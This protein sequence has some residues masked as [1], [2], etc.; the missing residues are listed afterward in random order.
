[1][2]S[3][4]I[5]LSSNV[6][7][8]LLELLVV[9]SIIAVLAGILLPVSQGVLENARKV[10]AKTT[11]QG[12][13]TAVKAYQTEYGQYPVEPPSPGAT[14]TDV[15]FDVGAP[16]LDSGQGGHTG[17]LFDVLRGLNN[18]T[19]STSSTSAAYK[20][21]N[22]RKIVFFEGKDVRNPLDPR[23]GFIPDKAGTKIK[24]GRLR[25]DLVDPWG[26]QFCVRI[27]ANYTDALAQPYPIT[28][29]FDGGQISYTK[30]TDTSTDTS[31]Q[32]LRL[33]VAVI[34]AGKDSKFGDADGKLTTSCDDVVSW[35]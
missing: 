25:G 34:S 4:F 18:N 6:F 12:I 28:G 27:D 1:M 16:N 32:L 3:F 8:T 26:N 17:L 24:A 21:L 19:D 33:S 30:A 13:I 11:A 10:D 29:N 35:Q 9:I 2:N 23:G 31:D 5:A 14:P 15:T 7:F 22:P 20:L